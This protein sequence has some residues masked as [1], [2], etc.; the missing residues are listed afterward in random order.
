MDPVL[1]LKNG[2]SGQKM[3]DDFW[4]LN[5]DVFL[6]LLEYGGEMSLALLGLGIGY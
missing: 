6:R 3:S 4:C 2:R 1:R 5:I